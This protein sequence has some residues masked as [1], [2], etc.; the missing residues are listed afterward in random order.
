MK[1]KPIIP[2]ERSCNN[3]GHFVSY[4]W[5]DGVGIGNNAAWCCRKEKEQQGGFF[6]DLEKLD[7]LY[8]W[9]IVKPTMHV[10]EDHYKGYGMH[11]VADY[12]VPFREV[13]NG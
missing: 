2:P 13:K 7:P 6:P 3:C 5:P 12:G 8:N 4:E 9:T 11:Y 10:C 1:P